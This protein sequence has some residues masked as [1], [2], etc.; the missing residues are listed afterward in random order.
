MAE[1]V[2]IMTVPCH[3]ALVAPVVW[4]LDTNARFPE[5]FAKAPKSPK[6]VSSHRHIVSSR[7]ARRNK[8][9]MP[10][11][12]AGALDRSMADEI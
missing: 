9:G 12:R 1:M 2:L 8:A 3:R 7:P 10:G 6:M 5:F 4:C 11:R